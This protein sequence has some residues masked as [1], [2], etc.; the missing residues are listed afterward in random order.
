[1]DPAAI[2]VHH[3]L[4][5]DAVQPLDLCEDQRPG[6]DQITA[7]AGAL[8]KCFIYEANAL[9]WPSNLLFE[10]IDLDLSSTGLKVQS[11]STPFTFQNARQYWLGFRH[12]QTATI[13]AVN[14]SSTVNLGLFNAVGTTY[15]TVLRRTVAF[16][17]PMPA[18]WVFDD[19]EITGNVAPPSV[20]MRAV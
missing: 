8:G 15:G 9:G 7:V 6:L 4:A 10:G 1:M 13:R 17:T 14:L 11:L 20:R 2:P 12:S 16:A 5:L 3:R 19:S 18:V